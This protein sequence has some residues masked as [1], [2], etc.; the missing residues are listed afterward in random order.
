MINNNRAAGHNATVLPGFNDFGRSMTPIFHLMDHFLLWFSMFSEKNRE[1]YQLEDISL[2]FLQNAPW[3]YLEVPFFSWF[4]KCNH[5]LEQRKTNIKQ[6]KRKRKNDEQKHH[7]SIMCSAFF[8]KEEIIHLSIVK[9]NIHECS[10]LLFKVNTF[11]SMI[12]KLLW[13]W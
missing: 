8:T 4:I 12:L 13:I 2:N 5:S 10:S 9:F 1:I 6:V 3:N 7:F 11:F